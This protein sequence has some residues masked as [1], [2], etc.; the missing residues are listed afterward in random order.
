MKS[1]VPPVVAVL[2][3]FA[4]PLPAQQALPDGAR[5]RVT[6]KQQGRVIGMLRSMS[7]DSISMVDSA[8]KEYVLARQDIAMEQSRGRGTHFWKHFGLSILAAGSVGGLIS[9]ATWSE[10][11]SCWIYPESRAE[12]FG[13][14][15]LAGGA[16]G[17]PV[18]VIMGAVVKVE[19]WE[20]VPLDAPVDGAQAPHA[21]T[22]RFAVSLS[23]PLR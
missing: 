2:L 10:C 19:R 23:L 4:G 9:A 13:W 1:F 15:F 16:I 12:A 11:S 14:G 3:F 21:G 20:F 8:G 18:G 5:V 6:Q 7:R 22:Q 17:V